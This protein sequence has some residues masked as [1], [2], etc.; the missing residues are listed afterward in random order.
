M[1]VF[2]WVCF[3]ALYSVPLI[4]LSLL[5]PVLS[6]NPSS[7]APHSKRHYSRDKFLIGR[8]FE[9]YSGRRPHGERKDSCPKSKL[10]LLLAQ[11]FLKGF[12]AADQQRERRG[13]Q[14]VS[15]TCRLHVPARHYLGA[16]G[17]CEGVRFLF[18]DML[19]DT[20]LSAN[21]G[22]FSRC[23]KGGD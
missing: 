6:W 9:L 11:G 19:E 22:K 14:R 15:S 12:R 21:E 23:T 20:V 1:T 5:S 8:E 17:L 10:R 4:C 2:I 3:W 13:P 7:A 16:R 18:C